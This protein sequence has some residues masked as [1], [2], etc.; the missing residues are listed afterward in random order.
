MATKFGEAKV[1]TGSERHTV[2]VFKWQNIPI[3][4]EQHLVR[5][6][7]N[8]FDKSEEKQINVPEITQKFFFLNG[9]KIIA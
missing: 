7:L 4:P 9:I 6:G 2:S 1:R 3:Q 5:P 8:Y